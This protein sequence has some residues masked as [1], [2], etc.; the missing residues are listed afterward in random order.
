MAKV[1]ESLKK[2]VRERAQNCCERCAANI[3]RMPDGSHNGSFHHRLPQRIA[4]VN[5]VSNLVLL[6]LKCHCEI[7]QDEL[8]ASREGW[9]AWVDPD[10]TP[11]LLMRRSWV[12]LVPDGSLEYLA[13]LEGER[14]LDWT[15]GITQPA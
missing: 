15:N 12:L 7:H 3:V 2:I 14:L 11:V 6:C 9:I 8:A 4:V 1:S 10:V 13:R 5:S